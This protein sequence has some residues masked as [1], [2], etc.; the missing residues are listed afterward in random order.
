MR[1]EPLFVRFANGTVSSLDILG[2]LIATTNHEPSKNIAEKAKELV[3]DLSVFRK[4]F[5][6]MIQDLIDNGIS[7]QLIN[8]VDSY[9]K[10]SLEE[11]VDS[12]NGGRTGERRYVII[13]AEDAPWI[14][15]LVCYNLCLFIKA[16]GVKE[17]KQCYTCK[18]YF[19]NKGKYAVYCSDSCK[20]SKRS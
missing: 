6:S 1:S 15:A 14:E 13:K 19:T 10:P 16:Y 9:M 4:D 5:C 17:I 18:K 2:S 8:Y 12:S 7:Q 20:G 11:I 3:V